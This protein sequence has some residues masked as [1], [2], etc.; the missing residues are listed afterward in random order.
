MKR[1]KTNETVR[2]FFFEEFC[3][4]FWLFTAIQLVSCILPPFQFNEWFSY[5]HFDFVL[6]SCL[7]FLSCFS[8]Y[9]PKCFVKYVFSPSLDDEKWNRIA[10]GS[11]DS[12][13]F[14]HCLLFVEGL[15]RSA[16]FT[17]FVSVWNFDWWVA[18]NQGSE[19]KPC[20]SLWMKSCCWLCWFFCVVTYLDFEWFWSISCVAT[21][22]IIWELPFRELNSDLRSACAVRGGKASS[23]ACCL[24]WQWCWRTCWKMGLA[25]LC[26]ASRF[27]G[28][29]N[30]QQRQDVSNGLFVSFRGV[31]GDGR[32]WE[33]AW[34][35]SWT[36]SSKHIGIERPSRVDHLAC[37]I[38]SLA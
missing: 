1:R 31:P 35:T 24:Q 19:W 16:A 6:L 13:W 10:G 9:A 12:I 17:M 18:T 7:C 29:A 30:G 34:T 36:S 27:E 37:M 4:T 5:F 8:T 15:K 14:L 23:C 21:I 26:S 2:C 32:K 22:L 28:K 38:M 20:F 25:M 3:F 11:S 33:A